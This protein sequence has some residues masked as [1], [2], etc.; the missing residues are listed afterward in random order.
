MTE[1]EISTQIQTW[2]AFRDSQPHEVAANFACEARS[3]LR[4]GKVD[5]AERK[6]A[7]ARNVAA[8]VE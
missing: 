1:D 7:A 8:G 6:M 4:A 2:S 3:H 5:L